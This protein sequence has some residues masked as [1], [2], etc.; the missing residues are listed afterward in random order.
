MTQ[1]TADISHLYRSMLRIRLVEEHIAAEYSKQEM[2]CPTHLSIGQEGVAAGVCAALQEKDE[3]FSGHR[4]HAHYLAKGGSLKRMIAEMMGKAEGCCGGMGGSM[5]LID[6][7]C[8]FRGSVPIVGSTIPIATGLAFQHQ[9]DGTGQV[10][11]AF[12]GEGATEEGVLHESLNFAALKKLPI[13]FACENNLYSVYSPLSV[14]QPEGRRVTELAEGHRMYTANVDGND[15]SA[16]NEVTAQAVEKARAGEGPS[17]IEY[18]T[19]R[20][21]EHC[22]P[23]FDNKLGYRTEQEYEDWRRKCPL[24]TAE[25]KLGYTPPTGLKDELQAE[26][27][28]AFAYARD[29]PAAQHADLRSLVYA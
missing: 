20:W 2:R 5:H 4:S 1:L 23:N 15:V 19:Y 9:I 21:R 17:F 10:V 28:E 22:G 8:G 26:I 18:T 29:L 12:L 16:V 3:I 6:K 14:R 11:V 7:A 13:L 27:E 25:E 24:A